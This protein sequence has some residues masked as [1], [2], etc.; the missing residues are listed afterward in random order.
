MLLILFRL[1]VCSVL[2]MMFPIAEFSSVIQDIKIE[3]IIA[4]IYESHSL[5]SF[6]PFPQLKF[7]TWTTT[8]HSLSH[9]LLSLLHH[10]LIKDI[11]Y[12]SYVKSTD[13]AHSTGTILVDYKE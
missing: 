1:G 4:K 9:F 5:G 13:P 12:H 11:F 3:E 8:L 7:D 2:E 10:S 6:P